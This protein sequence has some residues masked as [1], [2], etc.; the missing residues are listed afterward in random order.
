MKI[1]TETSRYGCRST[2]RIMRSVAGCGILRGMERGR[3]EA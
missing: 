1:Y 2:V 3:L